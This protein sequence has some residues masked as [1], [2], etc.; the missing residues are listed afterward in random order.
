MIIMI[1]TS[2]E[3]SDGDDQLTITK[4]YVNHNN[5]SIINMLIHYH[6]K[7][8]MIKGKAK[9][10]AKLIM[11][12]NMH[13]YMKIKCNMLQ[14]YESKKVTYHNVITTTIRYIVK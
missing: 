9:N 3:L 6:L 10:R 11:A 13:I 14:R 4:E 12:C 7:M 1:A 5:D 2:L 8:S